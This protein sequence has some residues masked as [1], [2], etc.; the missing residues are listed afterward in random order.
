MWHCWLTVNVASLAH[1]C[2]QCSCVAMVA[3]ST[4]FVLAWYCVGWMLEKVFWPVPNLSKVCTWGFQKFWILVRFLTEP[5]PLTCT[6]QSLQK[7]SAKIDLTMSKRPTFEGPTPSTPMRTILFSVFMR[8]PCDCLVSTNFWNTCDSLIQRHFK[9]TPK[10]K[11]QTAPG[12]SK[13]LHTN[14]LWRTH[15]S[16]CS[17]TALYTMHAHGRGG[18][19]G[20]HA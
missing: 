8:M 11:N 4:P 18:S 3:S 15:L 7:S 12:Q 14:I 6:W 20:Q 13:S 2:L 10:S 9:G 1:C 16:H 19:A 17:M 5:L